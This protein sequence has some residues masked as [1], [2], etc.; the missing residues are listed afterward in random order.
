MIAHTFDLNQVKSMLQIFSIMYKYTN[1]IT[2]LKYNKDVLQ[3]LKLSLYARALWLCSLEKV[4]V[5]SIVQKESVGLNL[6]CKMR[7]T[8]LTS[9]VPTP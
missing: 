5:T 6:Q 9:F 1:E 8:Q 7:P 2:G 3:I 4:Y